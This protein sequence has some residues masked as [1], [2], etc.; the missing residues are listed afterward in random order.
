M[1]AGRFILKILDVRCEFVF[2][3]KLQRTE[4]WRL[5]CKHGQLEMRLIIRDVF[6]K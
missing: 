6:H 3:P 2:D 4:P 1:E 5:L